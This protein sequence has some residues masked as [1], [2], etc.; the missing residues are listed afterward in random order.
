V[1]K[2]IGVDTEFQDLASRPVRRPPAR[3]AST[4]P[5]VDLGQQ[6]APKNQGFTSPYY[7]S[8]GAISAAGAPI[9]SLDD[10]KGK[11]V[12]VLSGRR[13][14]LGQANS[15]SSLRRDQGLQRQQDLLL[16]VQNGRLDAGAT[17][18]RVCSSR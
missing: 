5:F 6:R 3:A 16:E 4:S 2:R 18:S 12:G 10:L 13:R 8:D 11:T 1:A 17:E 7:D 9:K 15:T 14:G